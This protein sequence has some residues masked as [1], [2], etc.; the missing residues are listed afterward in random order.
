MQCGSYE[1]LPLHDR[2]VLIT[3]TVFNIV[4]ITA[5]RFNLGFPVFAH[6]NIKL[7]QKPLHA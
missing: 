7:D 1:L 3:K 2:Y 5:V 6:I 4:D